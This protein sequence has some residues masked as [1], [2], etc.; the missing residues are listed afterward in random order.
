MGAPEV[1]LRGA[2]AGYDPAVMPAVHALLQ[3]REDAERCANEVTAEELWLRPGGAASAGFHL[4][5]TAGALDRLFT[6]ARGE[7]LSSEQIEAMKQ[8]GQVPLSAAELL[9]VVSA[10]ID[11]ALAQLRDTAPPTL[12]DAREVGRA[13]LPATVI[14]LLFH[15][16]EHATR[17]VGQCITTLKIVRGL[18]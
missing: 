16:A 17:H 11:R 7:Q 13:K 2:V 14:G 9:A 4:Q 8:E 5:H 12:F 1:W 15:G 10:A 3:A 6:Y 18:R